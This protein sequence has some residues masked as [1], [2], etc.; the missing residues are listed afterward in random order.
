MSSEIC[1]MNVTFY[2]A[3]PCHICE[4]EVKICTIIPF[5][6]EFGTKFGNGWEVCDVLPLYGNLFRK[7]KNKD[8]KK[9]KKKKTQNSKS[10]NFFWASGENFQLVFQTDCISSVSYY[11]IFN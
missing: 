2:Y 3:N 10:I 1:I 7:S 9:R 11:F 4:V 6:L 5:R 8:F